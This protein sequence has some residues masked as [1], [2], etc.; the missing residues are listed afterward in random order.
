MR[1]RI[2]LTYYICSNIQKS[3]ILFVANSKAQKESCVITNKNKFTVLLVTFFMLGF[4]NVVSH[5]ANQVGKSE[6]ANQ[7]SLIENGLQSDVMF[8]GDPSW[9]IKQRMEHYGV[10]GVSIAVIKDHKV[11][12]VKHYGITDKQT[13]QAVSDETLFQAGSISKPVA[14][15]GALKLVESGKLSL[16]QPVNRYLK[17]WQIPENE[18]TKKRPVALK[19][20]LN[21][22]AGLTVHGFWGYSKG[23]PV[24]S[25]LQVLNGEKP[26]NSAPVVVDLLPETQMRYSGGGYTVMQKLVADVTE[27]NFPQALDDLVI[28]PIGMK[29]STYQQPLPPEKLKFAAAGYLPNKKPVPGKHHVYPEM[30][31][32]GLWTTAEDLAKFAIDVQLGIKSNQSKVL[33]QTMTEKMLTPWV[34]Q[35]VGLGFFIDSKKQGVYFG[36]GGWDE[37][38]SADLVAH[39]TAGYGVAIMTNSNHPAFIEELKNSIAAAYGWQEYLQPV[40]NKLT[41]S[42]S[43]LKRISGRYFFNPDMLFTIAK[44]QEKVMMRYLDGT[45]ME[46]FKVADNLYI[47]REQNRKFSFIENPETKQVELVFDMGNGT[48]VARRRLAEDEIIPFEAVIKDELG[49]AEK[50]YRQLLEK[51]PEM[52]EQ[53]EWHVLNQVERYVDSNQLD[54]AKRLVALNIKLFP[55]SVNS[56]NKQAQLA[57]QMSNNKL[58]RQVYKEIL[59]ILPEH[60]PAIEAL[61]ALSKD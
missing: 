23:L 24:P 52:K 3:V 28:N 51:T 58:A 40:Y 56:L 47:R 61:K 46:I 42:E 25:V 5:S 43:E 35:N 37:G 7:I 20:L 21:H 10:P 2:L 8:E 29:Q 44:E 27:K 54:K 17:G 45:A 1:A 13:N 57:L 55:K 32:A 14:A 33:S 19:H 26:A 34:S 16:D 15:Y 41:I 4:G 22:S 31:A 18:L 39:K 9:T 53:V 6:L 38:F 50:Q 36:H 48:T 60:Q 11:H 59:T 49:K 30:A 12:L